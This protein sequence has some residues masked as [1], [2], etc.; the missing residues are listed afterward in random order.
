MLILTAAAKFVSSAGSAPIL[1]HDAPL[2]MLPYRYVFFGVGL[3]EVIVAGICVFTKNMRVQCGLLGW[4]ATQFVAY[5]IG[6]RWLGVHYCGC[7]GT[8]TDALPIG[9][10]ATNALLAVFLCYLL[11]GSYTSCL[12]LYLQGRRIPQISLPLSQINAKVDV[13]AS[14]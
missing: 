6:S 4:L 8:V 2:F 12:L 5:R 11:I 10:E 13:R 7:L 1:D 9:E 14:H 3:I